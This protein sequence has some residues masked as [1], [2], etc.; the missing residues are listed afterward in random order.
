MYS[1][2]TF[3]LILCW[4]ALGAM[5]ILAHENDRMPRENKTLLYTTYLLVA[6]SAFAE[7]CGVQLDGRTEM[8]VWMLRIS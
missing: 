4:I 8:P 5:C 1:Y 2:Y 6:V 3:I 7:W